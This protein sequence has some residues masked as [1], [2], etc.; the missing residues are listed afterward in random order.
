MWT[1]NGLHISD[2]SGIPNDSTDYTTL[3]LI[4]GYAWQ[5]GNKYN[6]RVVLVNR[7]DYPGALPYTEEERAQ[8]LWPSP[9][10]AGAGA[11]ETKLATANVDAWLKVRGREVHSL[12]HELVEKENL[13]AAEPVKGTGGIVIAGWSFGTIWMTALLA[14]V[15]LSASAGEDA[16]DPGKYVR[17][18]VFFDPPFIALGYAP[19]P[20]PGYHPLLD[21]TTPP[22]ARPAAFAHWVGGYYAHGRTA[23]TLHCH[24]PLPHPHPPPT[25]DT[26]TPAERARTQCAMP[27]VPGVGSDALLL[28]TGL[29]VG[30]FAVLKDRALFPWGKGKRQGRGPGPEPEEEDAD[31]A[32]ANADGG[33][34]V[35]IQ[36]GDGLGVASVSPGT[37]EKDVQILWPD[38]EVRHVSCEHSV[39]DIPWC[40]WSLKA[41]LERANKAKECVRAVRLVHVRGANHFVH[42]DSPELALRALVGDEDLV[43]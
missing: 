2:D 24:P 33:G 12:L 25:L 13:P 29:R 18:V 38:V 23:A 14:S 30:A 5:S 27:A 28:E 41:E 42:W 37:A 35:A 19:P 10:E 8:L 22:S 7:R 17:R 32:Q 11:D 15:P 36:N 16:I 9:S 4:H 39:W 34:P 31:L 3:V 26:L 6:T 21:T 40:L 43:E 20:N 1:A